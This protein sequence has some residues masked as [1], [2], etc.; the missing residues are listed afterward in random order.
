M[1]GEAGPDVDLVPYSAVAHGIVQN[2]SPDG[3]SSAHKKCLN[4]LV[5][6][7]FTNRMGLHLVHFL[8]SL[9]L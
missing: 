3:Q 8:K 6:F 1:W 2:G 4:L 7:T 5:S 9:V